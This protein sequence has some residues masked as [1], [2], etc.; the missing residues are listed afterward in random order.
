MNAHHRK[1]LCRSARNSAEGEAVHTF[2]IQAGMQQLVR[3]AARGD[4]LL[5]LVLSDVDTLKC[6]VLPVV[7]DH[8]LVLAY[9]DLPVP[10]NEVCQ[11]VVS[12]FAKAD[13]D[14]LRD[15]VA[16]IDWS[17]LETCL[18]DYGA[19]HFTEVLLRLVERHI[20]KKVLKETKSTHPWVND[21]V[22]DL[23]RRKQQAAGTCEEKT[24]A[25]FAVRVS[26]RSLRNMWKSRRTAYASN[27]GQPKGGYP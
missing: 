14:A 18:A 4:H 25:E 17:F 3:D 6:I 23:V 1:W 24:A 13:W 27:L 7:A 15:D 22:M 2:C 19:K 8:R 5:D 12:Q 20:P 11:R 26:R 21:R 16:R 9:F 10:K